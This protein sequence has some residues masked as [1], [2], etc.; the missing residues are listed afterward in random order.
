MDLPIA[1]RLRLDLDPNTWSP[2]S[3]GTGT[4]NA[5]AWFMLTTQTVKQKL[6][7]STN[8]GTPIA[9]WFYKGNSH[10]S[11]WMIL[12][13]VSLWLWKPPVLEIGW[14]FG[15]FSPLR[16]FRRKS[17]SP[18]D[19]MVILQG[20]SYLD[21]VGGLHPIN[22]VV[23]PG[24]CMKNIGVAGPLKEPKSCKMSTYRTYIANKTKLLCC[25]WMTIYISI[26]I[27]GSYPL[28]I[29]MPGWEILIYV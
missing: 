17:F 20:E 28:A 23:N 22:D 25:P 27:H 10:P 14:T 7:V 12:Q 11:K 19:L 15:C 8:G 18:T 2:E 1:S 13:G 16:Q 3:S 24:W 4:F 26:P 9:G 21:H 5:S 29:N 6:E